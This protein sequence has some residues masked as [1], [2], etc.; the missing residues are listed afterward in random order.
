MVSTQ[1]VRDLAFKV[2]YGFRG[3][4]FDIAGQTIRLDESL[5]R[6]NVASE[7]AMQAV[8]RE[9]LTPGGVFVDV[10]ANFG[11]HTVYGAKLVG[12]KGRVYAF[13]PVPTNLALLHRNIAL[14]DVSGQVTVVEAAVSNST[15]AQLTFFLPV[16]EVAVTASLKPSQGNLKETKVANLRF[17]DYWKPIG[18]QITLMKIDVEGAELEVLRG[19]EA[20]LAEQRPPLVIEVHG[21]ALPDFGAS[22]AEVRDFLGRLGYRERRLEGDQFADEKYFQA[23]YLAERQ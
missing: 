5:R 10:G 18:D 9:F 2:R 4:P 14:S 19:A 11:L 22:V 21:F 7:G 1:K 20:T 17:D 6:W 13:E 23:L 8:F 3:V 12:E 16:E 15:E